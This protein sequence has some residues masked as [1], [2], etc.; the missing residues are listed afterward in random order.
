M[1]PKATLAQPTLSQA[2]TEALA[3]QQ[4]ANLRLMAHNPS[5]AQKEALDP[6]FDRKIAALLH[7][8]VSAADRQTLLSI[9]S[10]QRAQIAKD[11]SREQ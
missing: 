5:E 2:S 11:V 3:T 7:A 8:P 4:L 10:R 1:P 9:L 6:D